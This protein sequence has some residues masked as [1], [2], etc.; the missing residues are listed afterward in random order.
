MLLTVNDRANASRITEQRS[1]LWYSFR[2][3]GVAQLRIESGSLFLKQKTRQH[4]AVASCLRSVLVIRKNNI[5]SFMYFRDRQGELRSI[6]II[7]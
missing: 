6:S 4:Q 2:G 7:D 1:N 3:L 5:S